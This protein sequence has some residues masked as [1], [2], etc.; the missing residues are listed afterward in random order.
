MR[1]WLNTVLV[2]AVVAE[3]AVALWLWQAQR[4]AER[5]ELHPLF[6]RYEHCPD[7]AAG[8]VKNL[9]IADTVT[10]DAV[11]L[12]AKDT[13]TW[14]QL[15]ENMELLHATMKEIR[16]KYIEGKNNLHFYRMP[17]KTATYTQTETIDRKDFVVLDPK[18]LSICVYDVENDIQEDILLEKQFEKISSTNK[19][20]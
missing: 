5:S 14:F 3:A 11:T 12:Q 10:I 18:E 8:F 20:I 1:R 15:L 7:V 17:K 4:R 6:L 13:A 2:V 9:L 16:E 19:K